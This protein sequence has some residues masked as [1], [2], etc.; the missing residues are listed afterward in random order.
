MMTHADAQ[1]HGRIASPSPRASPAAAAVGG[2]GGSGRQRAPTCGATAAPACA[3][4]YAAHCSAV[5]GGITADKADAVG[6]DAARGQLAPAG[7][8]RS[9][10]SACTVVS[11]VTCVARPLPQHC[12]V[13]M[14]RQPQR[15]ATMRGRDAPT[16]A[17]PHGCSRGCVAAG[18]VSAASASFDEH[19][20]VAS[21]VIFR[22]GSEQRT[23]CVAEAGAVLRHEATDALAPEKR[24]RKPSPGCQAASAPRSAGAAVSG[25]RRRAAR[26]AQHRKARPRCP[27]RSAPHL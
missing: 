1:P 2:G 24:C 26:A 15:R 20:P 27:P 5:I 9:T 21:A 4:A 6:G 3:P 11:D 7:G 23:R 18:T 12:R 13:G 25:P 17:N 14:E 19:V 22:A 10:Y 8:A 16:Q